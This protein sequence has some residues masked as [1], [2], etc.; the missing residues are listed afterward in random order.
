[1]KLALDTSQS[2]GSIALHDGKRLLYSAYFDIRITHSETLMPAIDQALKLTQLSPA[3]LCEIYV[4]IGPGSFTG[5][6][7]GVATAKGIAFAKKIPM[8]S[9]NSLELAAFSFHNQG[10]PI[11][12]VND[13]KMQECYA[14]LYDEKLKLIRPEAVLSVKEILD[15][16]IDGSIVCGSLAS[17]FEPYQASHE[18]CIAPIWQN[19]ARAE[20]MFY[21]PQIIPPK[22]WENEDLASLE[23]FYLRESSAQIKARQKK[24]QE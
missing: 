7:I 1:M 10:R 17:A 9:Y 22:L 11:L 18:L 3:E 24:L 5:L 2:S 20:M 13:A 16:Q 15:W 12:V 6:R 19:T 8:Y 4:C 21:M 14:A 23:P